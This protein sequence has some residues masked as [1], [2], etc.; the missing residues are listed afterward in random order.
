MSVAN[1]RIRTDDGVALVVR[2]LP[3]RP[4]PGHAPESQATAFVVAHGFTGA[5]DRPAVQR[6][7]EVLS[8]F[9]GVLVPDLRGHGGS[10]GVT[11]FGGREVLDIDA[12]VRHARELGYG[13]VVSCGWSMGGVAVIRH[14]ALTGLSAAAVRADE[15]HHLHPSHPVG[16]VASISAPSRW[17]V[18]D[19]VA[20]RRLHLLAETRGGR[21]V[22]R[23]MLGVRM[24][25]G[26]PAVPPW[27]ALECAAAVA[28]VPLLVVHGDSD[29]YLP[30]WHGRTLAAAGGSGVTFWLEEGFGHAEVAADAALVE[31]VGRFL[32]AA[33]R[34]GQGAPGTIQTPQAGA[35]EHMARATVR[36]WAAAREAAGL[37]EEQHDGRTL[38][39]VLGAAV[40]RHGERLAAVVSRSS[41]VV[42]GQTVGRRDPGTVDIGDGGVVE[43][44]P[45]FAGGAGADTVPRRG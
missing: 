17:Y 15:Q 9:G 26:P 13:T 5:G 24:G 35:R 40:A 28:P 43:I 25:A 2:H 36:Y 21:W 31:R 14:A 30:A 7:T 10:A 8:R 41:F 27:S 11:T 32:V 23:R 19:T 37:V 6:I 45:P 22:G 3:A 42:D 33:A 34:T 18:R 12:T 1:R 39:E 38:A 44:L 29:R 4:S 16:A 20:M